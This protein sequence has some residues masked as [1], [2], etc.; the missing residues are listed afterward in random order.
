MEFLV[1]DVLE[2][3]HAEGAVGGIQV[4]LA[5]DVDVA[6]VV[7]TVADEVGDGYEREVVGGAVL[8]EL[9]KPRHS[10]V[11]VH[12]FADDA[13]GGAAGEAGEIDS[14]FRLTGAD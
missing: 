8:D 7:E 5:Q 13:A 6:F 3:E 4:C 2:E 9:G 11:G 12:D 14:G 1:E 10:A